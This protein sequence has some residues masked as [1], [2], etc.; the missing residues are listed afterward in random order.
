MKGETV[1]WCKALERTQTSESLQASDFFPTPILPPL[2]LSF[3]WS[4]GS[5]FHK[6]KILGAPTIFSLGNCGAPKLSQSKG[7]DIWVRTKGQGVQTN[8]RPVKGRSSGSDAG[9][10]FCSLRHSGAFCAGCTL[11]LPGAF[12]HFYPCLG[13]IP[14]GSDLIGPEE[15]PSHW[16]VWICISSKRSEL[17]LIKLYTALTCQAVLWV[18]YGQLIHN[19]HETGRHHGH[20][21]RVTDEETEAQRSLETCPKSQ[22]EPVAEAG[23]KPV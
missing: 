1:F 9:F 20:H 18:L 19:T 2:G 11:E 14:R 3:L 5:R 17:N 4:R 12:K 6:T 10:V 15:I 21:L 16:P 8:P 22:S 7:T 13:S 23:C